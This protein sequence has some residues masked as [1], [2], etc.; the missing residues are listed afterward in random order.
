M[1]LNT[2][3]NM[4]GRHPLEKWGMASITLVAALLIGYVAY[5]A[6]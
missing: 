6:A 1:A 4:S 2:M 5:T 3:S